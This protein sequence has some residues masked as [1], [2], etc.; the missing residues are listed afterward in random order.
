VSIARHYH[1]HLSHS[2]I[3]TSLL[4]VNAGD[5]D[6]KRQTNIYQ[7]GSAALGP[8]PGVDHLNGP[9]VPAPLTW[10]DLLAELNQDR[11]VCVRVAWAG[12]GAHILAVRGAFTDAAGD[13]IDVA[14]PYSG[15]ASRLFKD[16]P[17]NHGPVVPP[18]ATHTWTHS[19]RTRP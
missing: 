11:P 3:A 12:G 17:S 18:G 6:F 13:H 16:F 5:V 15:Y 9:P 2:D 1:N 19:Y 14:D 8:P 10:N 7:S 4:G